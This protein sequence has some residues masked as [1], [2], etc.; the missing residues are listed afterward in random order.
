MMHEGGDKAK[1]KT[2]KDNLMFEIENYKG[3]VARELT[4]GI[5]KEPHT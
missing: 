4:T 1:L 5:W 3:I 2:T